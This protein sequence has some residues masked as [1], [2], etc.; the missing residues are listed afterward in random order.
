MGYTPSATGTRYRDPSPLTAAPP[1]I[2]KASL[3]ITVNIP[4]GITLRR[5]D[6]PAVTGPAMKPPTARTNL[7]AMGV[8]AAVAR[9]SP[10]SL[11]GVYG[12]A[13]RTAEKAPFNPFALLIAAKSTLGVGG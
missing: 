7:T 3:L 5:I 2:V 11:G 9:N 10:K 1:E 6:G 8:I 12:I 4:I 13:L